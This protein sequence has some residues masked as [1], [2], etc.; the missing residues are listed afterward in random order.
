MAGTGVYTFTPTGPTPPAN[1]V[2]DIELSDGT[3][4]DT[5]SVIINITA[6]NDAPSITSNGGGETASVNGQ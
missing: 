4:T 3:L 6:V 5:E 1:C 2:A